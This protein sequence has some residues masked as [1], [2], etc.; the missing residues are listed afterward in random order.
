MAGRTSR[1]NRDEMETAFID[2]LRYAAER[3]QKVNMGTTAVSEIN[4]IAA[5]TKC[6]K[7]ILYTFKGSKSVILIFASI[8]NWDQ[9]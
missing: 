7:V 3:L 5:Q 2:N 4:I 1:Y 8:L 6:F 9:L